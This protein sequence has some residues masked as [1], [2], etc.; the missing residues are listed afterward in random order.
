MKNA[1]QLRT[2]KCD[3]PTNVPKPQTNP[4]N[5]F[6]ILILLINSYGISSRISKK[7][8]KEDKKGERGQ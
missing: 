4:Y 6:L 3:N 5:L 1:K 7:K 8:T 2:S